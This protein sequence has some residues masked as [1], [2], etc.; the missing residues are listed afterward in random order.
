MFFRHFGQNVDILG[1]TDFLG[2]ATAT[3]TRSGFCQITVNDAEQV[4]LRE[5]EIE[6][7]QVTTD[8]YQRCYK[9]LYWSGKKYIYKPLN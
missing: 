3:R 6:I 4:P 8:L 9:N 1:K 2:K 5:Y 7:S